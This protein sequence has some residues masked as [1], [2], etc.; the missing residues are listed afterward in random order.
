[1]KGGGVKTWQGTNP[2]SLKRPLNVAVSLI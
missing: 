2:P 1:M